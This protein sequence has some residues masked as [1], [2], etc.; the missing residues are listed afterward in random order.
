[1]SPQ[2]FVLV[3]TRAV[4]EI[5]ELYAAGASLVIPEE[6]ETSIEIFTAVLHEYHVPNNVI[7]AQVTVLRQERYSL[8]RGRRLS[9]EV[10]EQLDAVLTQGTT[11]AVVLLHHS[12]AIGR[13]L[14]EVGLLSDPKVQPVALV[15]GGKAQV[16]FDPGFVL[17][18]GDTL[19]VTG[20]HGDID[21]VIERLAPPLPG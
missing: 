11:E 7:D 18:P 4:S 19:V 14:A 12:P 1:M 20:G 13:T 6:F 8:L 10:I 16:E 9:R 2:V 3:R 15:R 5:D 21:R 17:R